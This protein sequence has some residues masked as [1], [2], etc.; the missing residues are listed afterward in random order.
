MRR[1]ATL[2]VGLVAFGVALAALAG[3]S[4]LL[5]QR[6]AWDDPAPPVL[7][8]ATLREQGL[9]LFAAKG[10]TVC[11]RQVEA[12]K[13]GY[14]SSSGVGPDLTDL[15]ERFPPAS[16]SLS[17]LRRWLKSPSA[18]RPD[19]VMPTLGLDDAEIDGLLRFLLTEEHFA[20][21]TL[22]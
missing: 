10:C 17:Y 20:S 4:L 6:E 19:T 2:L 15:S 13:R 12:A 18:V 3:A 14:R 22:N 16:A 5:A 1:P 11:H 9:L 8:H 7:D 21:D